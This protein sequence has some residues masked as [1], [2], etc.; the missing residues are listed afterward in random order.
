MSVQHTR[1]RVSVAAV[2]ALNVLFPA[3]SVQVGETRQE[4]SGDLISASA[5]AT[6]KKSERR[7]ARG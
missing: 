4:S 7:R 1:S 5:K 6:G 2:R 3:A